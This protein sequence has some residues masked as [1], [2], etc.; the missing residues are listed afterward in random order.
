MLPLLSERVVNDPHTVVTLC[1]RLFILHSQPPHVSIVSPRSAVL[2]ATLPTKKDIVGGKSQGY[3]LVSRAVYSGVRGLMMPESTV[4]SRHRRCQ[5][6]LT[7][8][9]LLDVS[10]TYRWF[11]PLHP[12]P[13]HATGCIQYMVL[14]SYLYTPI[15]T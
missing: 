14:A 10:L 13:L 9:C 3:N 4:S 8:I 6:L 1:K 11:G 2:P 12:H 7:T 15:S 5:P